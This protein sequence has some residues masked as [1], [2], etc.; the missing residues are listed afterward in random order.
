[1][2]ESDQ[3][4]TYRTVPRE[5]VITNRALE[6]GNIE[7]WTNIIASYRQLHPDHEV[8]IL[9]EGEPVNSMLSLYKRGEAL[10]LSAFQ[11]AVSAP[12]SNWKDVPKLYRYLVE[13]ASPGY[14]KFIEKELHKVLKLF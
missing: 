10:N 12:D 1:M 3:K 4:A 13:G 11:L 2:T 5:I 8:I 7:A 9:Y 14:K 6:Y